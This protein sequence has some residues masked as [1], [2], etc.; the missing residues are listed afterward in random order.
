MTV[1][2]SDQIT[3]RLSHLLRGGSAGISLLLYTEN[4]VDDHAITSQEIR[5]SYLNELLW[6]AA[7]FFR[8]PVLDSQSKPL[9]EVNHSEPAIHML[10]HP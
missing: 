9:G 10:R 3:A 4:S 8:L 7:R 6:V 1:F 5:G 2:P